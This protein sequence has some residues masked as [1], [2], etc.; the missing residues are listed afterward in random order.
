MR[1]PLLL[2]APVSAIALAES[3]SV[4]IHVDVPEGIGRGCWPVT[5]GVPFPK[6]SLRSE[7]AVHV[8]ANGKPVPT[9][10]TPLAT[11]TKRGRHVRWL[12]LDF[13]V[14]AARAAQTTYCLVRGASAP[15]DPRLGVSRYDGGILVDTGA[16]QFAVRD[17]GHFCIESVKTGGRELVGAGDPISFFVTDQRNATYR[18]SADEALIED[19]GPLRL[20]LKSEG[21]YASEDGSRFCR[22]VIRLEFFAGLSLVRVLHTFIFTGTSDGSQIRDLGFEVPLEGST[23]PPATFGTDGGNLPASHAVEPPRHAYL[24]Q[25][26]A[27]RFDLT[28]DLVDAKSKKPL[29]SGKK[30]GGWLHLGDRTGAGVTIALREAWQN[31]PN[32]LE[33][34]GS[35]AIVHLWPLHGRM[36]DFRTKALLA[37]YGEEGIKTIDQFF[38]RQRKPYKRSIFDVYNNAM[39]V[40]KTHEV[41]LDFSADGADGFD[42]QVVTQANRPVLASADPAWSC[43][44]RALGPL[45][46]RD[47]ETFPAAEEALDA[48]FDRF[49][50][51]RDLYADFGWFDYQDVHCGARADSFSHPVAGGRCATLWRYWDSTHYGFPN[52]PWMLYFR[53]GKREYLE[54]A[55]ANARHCMDIDRCHHGDDVN[56]IKGT[57]YYCDW[58]II[59]WGGKPPNYVM[60]ANYDKLEYL[61]YAYYL[62][63][64][65]RGLDV[66]KDWGEAVARFHSDTSKAFPLRML[67]PNYKNIRHFGPPLGN[68]TEL[69]RVTW[70]ERYLDIARDYAKALLD[71]FPDAD[72]FGR[73]RGKLRF[74]WQG[75]ANYADLTG[76]RA[77]T[78]VLVRYARGMANRGGDYSFGDVGYA[79]ELTKDERFLDLGK[80]RLIQ[81]LAK[82]NQGRDIAQRGSAGAWVCGGHPYSIRSIPVLLSAMASAPQEWRTANLPLIPTNRSF[83]M[84]GPRLPTLHVEPGRSAKLA[85]RLGLKQAVDSHAASGEV[86]KHVEAPADGMVELDASNVHRITFPLRPTRHAGDYIDRGNIDLVR[87]ED[88]KL[89]IGP[90]TEDGHFCIFGTRFYFVVPAGVEQF[91]VTVE[92]SDPWG[93][94]T[95]APNV[96][97]FA[98]NGSTAASGEGPGQFVLTVT[99]KPGQTG[100]LWSI[101]P[102]GRV[103]TPRGN[104]TWKKP[105]RPFDAHFPAWFRLSSNLPQVVASHPDFFFDPTSH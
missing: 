8:T 13:Q 3:F 32:E 66:M 83:H 38:L 95:W 87:A 73:Y 91:A 6:G 1:T 26:H 33:V 24:V 15:P 60:L 94:Y 39:G 27:T 84:A 55:E 102:L 18:A 67:R 49:V 93:A 5:F 34:L 68:L 19:R 79:Y 36:L 47:P 69:Y 45:C 21:W 53:S 100:K 51:W 76:D 31:Y 37:P 11:W 71:M 64:Y 42:A 65:R 74:I 82:V 48:M 58:S 92:T 41:W 25:D 61:L 57:H 10:T 2:L 40:A 72:T 104:E 75:T 56:R 90:S 12:L 81:M 99:P 16:A 59:P 103:S 43:A 28:F 86:L 63:G 23:S 62:R 29:V 46:H 44:S 14:D 70:D 17:R 9:Q 89:A 7:T 98:P 88:M 20:G 105:R 77:L 54:L 96:H 85:M 50:Y 78:D 4:P 101:G 35:R 52:G 97:I 22:H 80:A 30:A